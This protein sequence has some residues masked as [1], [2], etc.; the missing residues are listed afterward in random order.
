MKTYNSNPMYNQGSGNKWTIGKKLIVSFMS[1]AAITLVVALIG[2]VGAKVL[3]D[4]TS[5]LGEVRLPSVESML[6]ARLAAETIHGE[7]NKLVASGAMTFEERTKAYQTIERGLT[8]YQDAIDRFVPLPQTEEEARIW[9]DYD[10]IAS[11]WKNQI[12]IFLEHAKDFDE[13]GIENPTQFAGLL[14]EYMKD[15]YLVTQDV[16]EMIYVSNEVFPGGDDHTACNAGQYLPAYESSNRE[17]MALIDE[18]DAYHETFHR[19]VAEIKETVADGNLA[20]ANEHYQNDMLPAMDG[21]FGSF[22]EMLGFADQAVD[23][24]EEVQTQLNGPYAEA[25]DNRAELMLAVTN[26]NEQ[27]ADQ[28]VENADSNATL[29]ETASLVGLVLGVGL[30]LVL[31]FLISRSISGNLREIIESLNSGAEQVNASS[32]Q[33]SGASQELSESASEQAAGLEETTS[34]L[35]EMA[36]Q[37]KQTA[38][39]ANQAELAVKETEPRVAKGVEAME[40][41]TKAMGDIQEASEATSKI[42][43]T[44]D[45]IAFQTNLLALNAA[46]EAAR[47]GEAGKGFAVVAEE[48]R[49]LAQRSA[50]AAQDTSELIEK[51][52]T[53]SERGS[54][55]AK[56]VSENLNLIKDSVSQ[57]GTLVLEISA[58]GK[59]QATG[60][61]EI[62]SVMTEMDKVVQQN[63]SSSEESASAAEELSSQAN[64]LKQVVN[65]L[66]DLVGKGNQGRSGN[67]SAT[68]FISG[69]SSK[70]K[71]GAMVRNPQNGNNNGSS[72]SSG[73]GHSSYSNG[74]SY[75]NGNGSQA[76]NGSRGKDLIPLEDDDFSEF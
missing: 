36:T 63:A 20:L 19:E 45:D 71:S 1:V 60:I 8:D 70:L 13:L 73:N 26:L 34:S 66:V 47:A 6:E 25:K 37:T 56:E 30:A 39:N 28:E 58:A 62:N 38:E 51:S 42:L 65:Q 33:L 3:S 11:S 21:V 31:G 27:I 69:V 46:V 44:I 50:Q 10:G 2:F 59:E 18:F 14:E 15:H 22:N 9:A 24:L 43:K 72:V 16:L 67:S 61:S 52:H 7:M 32:E 17:I 41:M 12:E 5:E 55:V 76:S 4:G 53:S 54:K 29:V 68:S 23:E 40:R 48:V 49:N 35:E 74:K 64:E 57:V 75:A